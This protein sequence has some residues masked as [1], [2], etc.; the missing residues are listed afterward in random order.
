MIFSTTGHMHNLQAATPNLGVYPQGNPYTWK[1]PAQ[2]EPWG[3]NS[4]DEIQ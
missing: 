3:K 2:M 4:M 1:K